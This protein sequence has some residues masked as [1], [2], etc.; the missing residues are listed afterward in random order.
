MSDLVS[1]EQRE[2][3]RVIDERVSDRFELL[4]SDSWEQCK[5]MIVEGKE[6]ERVTDVS[7]ERER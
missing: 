4:E 5:I 6:K 2:R 3:E 7:R 1:W